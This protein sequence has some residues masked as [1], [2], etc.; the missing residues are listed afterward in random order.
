[1][2]VFFC[3]SFLTAQ[4]VYEDALTA[5]SYA[6]SHSKKAHG[7]NNVFHTQEYADK[8]VEAFEKVEA[9]ANQCGCKK[10]NEMAF[11]AKT[12]MVNALDQDTY[13]RSRY[14]VKQAKEIG[15]RLLEMLTDCQYNS[16]SY[17]DTDDIASV[18]GN[19]LSEAS[20]EIA[21]KQQELEA[22]QQELLKQQKAIAQQIAE[23]EHIKSQLEAK[24]AAEL[25]QQTLI[26]SKAEQALQ[27]LESALKELSVA[28]DDKAT[29]ESNK[30]VYVRNEND[31]KNESIEDTKSFYIDRAKELTR[32]AIQ[33][34]AGYVED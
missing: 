14:Y 16:S 1:M 5:A 30:E 13:E 3:S 24:R 4:D 17:I 8:A 25:Q 26:K 34:F 23:Q 19:E 11:N 32:T 31:L 9:L 15:P 2:F 21:R 28:F 6:Y 10:A 18:E 22:K 29:F 33:Q 27:K 12:N 7:A 20:D